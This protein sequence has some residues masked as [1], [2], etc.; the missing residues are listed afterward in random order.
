MPEQL[1]KVD[2]SALRANQTMIIGLLI[3]AFVSNA[4]W[5]VA[6]VALVMAYGTASQQPG[7]KVFYTRLFRPLGVFKPYVL[8]DNPEPH[9]FAQALGSAVLFGAVIAFWGGLA[10]A[11]WGLAWL[12]VA[13]AALNVFAGMCVGCAIYYWLNRLHIPGFTKTPPPGT[14]PGMRPKGAD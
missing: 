13:L 8:N 14:F 5:L 12:V 9:L 6:L 7:F 3:G 4:Y 2:H 1:Q 11:G 10:A